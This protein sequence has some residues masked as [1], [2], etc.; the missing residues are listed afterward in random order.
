[1][2]V[3]HIPKHDLPAFKLKLKKLG[4]EICGACAMLNLGPESCKV[5]PDPDDL[6]ACAAEA[7]EDGMIKDDTVC[8]TALADHDDDDVV[9]PGLETHNGFGTY[10]GPRR[11]KTRVPVRRRNGPSPA[12]AAPPPG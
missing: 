8:L 1:M 7:K 6:A 9:I 3:R 4:W 12:A 11:S 5:L 10:L 2:R